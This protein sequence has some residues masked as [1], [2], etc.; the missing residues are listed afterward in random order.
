MKITILDR[1]TVTAG[2]LSLAPIEAL[3]EV[4]IF[5]ALPHDAVADAI[6]DSDAVIINKAR[7]TAEIMD[8]CKNLRFIGLF[9]TGYN[10]VDTAA[11]RARG[12]DVCNVPGYSTDSV[13]QHVF[14]MMLHFAS[15]ADDYAASVA[16]GS[17]VTAKTFSYFAFPTTELSGKTLGI[18]GLGTIGRAIAKI[19]CAFG[20]RVIATARRP[21]VC[22]LPEGVTLVSFDELLRQSD[23]L[24]LHCPLT[25]ETRRLI[26]EDA[27]N[28]M[29]PTAV[30]IN[31]ARGAVVD[32]QA[33]ADALNEGRL[34][35]AGIDVLEEEPMRAEHPYLTAKNCYVTPHVAWATIEARTRLVEIV[36]ENLRAF[37]DGKPIHV[38][39]P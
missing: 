7:I 18:F 25:D 22:M 3:G 8:A 35:G 29:K 12:I 11:A 27:L 39:N 28:R 9:A 30:L 15:R 31:T 16:S 38:V 6:A 23:Y 1:N 37:A 14:A 33:L 19:A 20:M 36:S 26:D 24:T 5:D 17:W 10:N 34:R 21:S 32:E 4:R 2:D 13:A